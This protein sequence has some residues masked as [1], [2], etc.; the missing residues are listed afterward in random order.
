MSSVELE[1]QVSSASDLEHAESI[2]ARRQHSLPEERSSFK[3]SRWYNRIFCFILFF[4][5]ASASFYGFYEKWHFREAGP[6]FVIKPD[7]E[8]QQMVEGSAARPYIYRQMLPTLA[9]WIDKAAP[10]PLKARLFQ[11]SPPRADGLS[12]PALLFDSPVGRSPVYFFRYLVVYS[13]TFLFALIAV[14]AMRL[15]CKAAGFNE[16]ASVLTPIAL[17]LLFPYIQSRG[18]YFYDFPELAF[19]ALAA[20]LALKFDWWWI[21]PVAAL[22]TWNKESFLL[23]IPTLYPILRLK[24]PRFKTLLALGFLCLVCIAVYLPL[25]LQFAHNPGGTV[26]IHWRDQAEFFFLHPGHWF[27]HGSALE[28]TYGILL[29]PVFSL[30]PLAFLVWTVWRGWRRLPLPIQRHAQIAAAINIPLFLVLCAPGEL[31]D[32]S[33]L[34]VGFLLLL[35]AN[36]DSWL[37]S[38]TKSHAATMGLERTIV[39]GR[40]P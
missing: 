12:L 40:R 3:V 34:Y 21:V 8:F 31:R 7:L 1:L 18:G 30:F 10:Q 25:R 27:Y 33:L 9:N 11:L 37:Q 32:L 16:A 20:W 5:A 19:L 22:G 39:T 17:I 13:A 26:E 15:L 14:Y 23:F 38:A 35:A 6:R 36:I 28:N 2:Y 29:P 24:Y 4:A